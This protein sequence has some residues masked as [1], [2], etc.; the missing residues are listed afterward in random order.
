MKR[1]GLDARTHTPAPAGAGTSPRGPI[2]KGL[3]LLGALAVYAGALWILF[4]LGCL[5]VGVALRL[6]QWAVGA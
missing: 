5:A 3:Y 6:A 1:S 2:G 4:V